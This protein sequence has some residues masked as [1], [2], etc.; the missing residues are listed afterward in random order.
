MGAGPQAATGRI[1]LLVGV[2]FWNRILTCFY[3]T[4]T[5]S[6]IRDRKHRE[7]SGNKQVKRRGRGSYLDRS[8]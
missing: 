3:Q 2:L 1:P 7:N 4:E 6:P 5:E 8:P